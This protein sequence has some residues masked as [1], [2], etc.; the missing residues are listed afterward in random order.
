MTI[1]MDRLREARDAAEREYLDD[2]SCSA[3]TVSIG[4]DPKTNE[5]CVIVKVPEKKKLSLLNGDK[6]VQPFY[7]VQG[8]DIRIKVIQE[9]LHRT[10]QLVIRSLTKHNFISNRPPYFSTGGHRDCHDLV[11]GGAQCQ[12]AR[13]NW[14]GTWGCACRFQHNGRTIRGG[15]SNNHVLYGGQTRDGTVVGSPDSSRPFAVVSNIKSIN[16]SGGNNLMDWT[17]AEAVNSANGKDRTS[18]EQIGLGKLN[19]NP[20][21][22]YQL[23]QQGIRKTGRTTGTQK[24]GQIVEIAVTT[25]VDHGGGKLAKFVNQI[26]IRD[27]NG[28]QFSNSGDSGSLIMTS[29]NRPLAHLHAGGGGTTIAAPIGP[30]VEEMQIEFWK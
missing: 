21:F 29:D 18:L 24:N 16:F 13:V 7:R 9:D 28:G 11:P 6:P 14:V 10:M 4:F 1:D 26:A 22:E 23:G 8:K 25:M 5:P 27:V 15:F 19:P 12:P 20:Q 17:G 30:I 3:N 2:D